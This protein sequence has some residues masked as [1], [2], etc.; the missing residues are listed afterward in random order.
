MGV[1][2]VQSVSSAQAITH[3]GIFHIGDVLATAILAQV[4]PDL[5]V[6]RVV[7]LPFDAV[8]DTL[9]YDLDNVV[10]DGYSQNRRCDRP[11]GI[12]YAAAGQA[13]R[14]FG[15]RICAELEDTPGTW[16]L[17]DQYLVQ[18][19]DAND[20][21]STPTS[22]LSAQIMSVAQAVSL[23]NSQWAMDTSDAGNA[24]STASDHAFIQAV[25]FI[26]I[27]LKNTIRYAEA[28]LRTGTQVIAHSSK[29]GVMPWEEA[30]IEAEIDPDICAESLKIKLCEDCGK[31]AYVQSDGTIRVIGLGSGFFPR[32]DKDD[33]LVLKELLRSCGYRGLNYYA[34]CRKLVF[35]YDGK[36]IEELKAELKRRALLNESRREIREGRRQAWN[37]QMA[38]L[39]GFMIGI[40]DIDSYDRGFAVW[41]SLNTRYSF[42]QQK[43][44]VQSRRENIIAFVE[45]E[46]PQ[47]KRLKQQ[48]DLLPFCH[49]AEI[50]VT[51]QN[52]VVV[53]YEL[54][55][56]IQELLK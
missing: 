36:N 40:T 27:V 37:K 19:A 18:G 21:T 41:I 4:I 56:E 10:F 35:S 46:L 16:L 7:H 50:I 52:A 28:E 26:E 22:G 14:K 13:W 3:A 32:D 12:P 29:T 54:K 49:V 11:N 43:K 45:E 47:K 2:I 31:A 25:E 9:I 51:R 30:V 15:P 53:K 23:F 42:D 6:A 33:K 5:A 39:G 48:A 44:F 17:V 20:H 38:E 8:Q 55:P 34:Q 24:R 1:K